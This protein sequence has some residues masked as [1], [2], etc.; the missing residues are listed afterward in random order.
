MKKMITALA[1]SCVMLFAGCSCNALER[2]SL[3]S[4][5]G[6]NE[7]AG[8]LYETAVYD[9]EFNTN[10]T[11]GGDAY[12]YSQTPSIKDKFD[13]N[14]TE[15][16]YKT[17][18]KVVDKANATLN[19]GT[20]T[21]KV[22]SDILTNILVPDLDNPSNS[23]TALIY[24]K[25]TAILKGTYEINGTPSTDTF[26][27]LIIT[28]SYFARTSYSLAPVYTRKIVRTNIV[29]IGFEGENVKADYATTRYVAET[30]YNQN[31]YTTK[32]YKNSE[33]EKP[34]D[35]YITAYTN[36]DYTTLATISPS[37]TKT[38]NYT[39][40]TAIDNSAL[41]LASRCMTVKKDET[42]NLL[43]IDSAYGSAMSIKNKCYAS[44]EIDLTS[45]ANIGS[46]VNTDCFALGLNQ[47]NTGR[48]KLVF[49]QNAVASGDLATNVRA[50]VRYIEPITEYRS[51]L[52]LGALEFTL[53]SI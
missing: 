38:Y 27:D 28:E 1:L 46:K 44:T 47:D 39:F 17:E 26:D 33:T 7:K 32:I 13:M 6:D 50:V 51:Y 37:E 10:V 21:D 49:V 31:N 5:W 45:N 48:Q 19:G 18:L 12:N 8:M 25:T 22:E 23:E 24:Y 3:T 2:L 52:C 16:S 15:G 42:K 20:L 4:P 9:V 41:L 29:G 43:V 34:V 30:V 36:D 11:T 35:N 14:I 53:Q 40:R